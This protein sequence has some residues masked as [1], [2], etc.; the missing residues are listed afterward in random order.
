MITKA[1]VLYGDEFAGLLE[2]ID[3][4]YK[5]SYEPKYLAGKSPKLLALLYLYLSILIIVT[6][7][8]HFSTD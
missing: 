8:F 4:G 7:Y 2:R 1:K 6:S 3:T 5:F